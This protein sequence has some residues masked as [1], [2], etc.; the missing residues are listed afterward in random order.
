MFE[1][2]G[3][4]VCFGGIDELFNALVRAAP[5]EQLVLSIAKD[6]LGVAPILDSATAVV[7]TE[8][9]NQTGEIHR[10][11]SGRPASYG[12]ISRGWT[13]DRDVSNLLESQLFEAKNKPIALLLGTAGVGKTTSV[14][15][16]LLRLVD[17]EIECWEHK[18]NFAF[19][20]DAWIKVDAE[21]RKRQSHGVLFVDEA[22]LFLRELNRLIEVLAKHDDFCLKIVLTSSRSHWNPRLKTAEYFR[23]SE[24]Y[25]LSRLSSCLVPASGGS[26]LG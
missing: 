24:E 8:R 10:M 22:H 17:R 20:A 6:A 7:S 9:A 11:F 3:L 13:F 5:A 18:N 14:R 25:N 23:L 1:A 21:L 12:D 16:T 26:G 15:Q 19:E 4:S 2:R